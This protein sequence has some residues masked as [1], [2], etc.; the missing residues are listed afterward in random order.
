M[1]NHIIS[2]VKGALSNVTDL[3]FDEEMAKYDDEGNLTLQATAA[4][5]EYQE[6]V[7]QCET[8]LQQFSVAYPS[9]A[10]VRV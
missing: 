4:I 5:A 6:M 2:L 3:V 9:P 7:A 8:A 1:S 10:L